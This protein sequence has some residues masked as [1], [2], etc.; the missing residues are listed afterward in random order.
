MTIAFFVKK[1]FIFL[2]FSNNIY[3]FQRH[4]IRLFY[5]LPIRICTIHTIEID[6]Q[7]TVFC[8]R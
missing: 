1:Q 4:V 7:I 8:K 5:E 6:F 2:V 3:I